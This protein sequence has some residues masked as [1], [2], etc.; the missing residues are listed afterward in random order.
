MTIMTTQPPTL[1]ASTTGRGAR[2]I[3]G[4]LAFS[5]GWT[6][7]FWALAGVTA[8]TVWAMPAVILFVIGGAGVLLGGVVMSRATYGRDGLRDLG[9]RIVDPRPIAGRWW[10]V[11]LLLF[12]ALV[13][14]SAGVGYLLGWSAAPVDLEGAAARLV[15]PA[16]LLGMVL[17]ILIIGPL[18][19]E[20]GWRGYLLDRLQLRW[21]ALVATLIIA[22]IWWSWHLPL[23]ALPGYFDAFGRDTP[24]PL[25]FLA[26]LV[27]AAILYTWVYNNTGRSVLAVILFHF[28]QNFSS[29]FL[30]IAA[31]TRPILLVLT[32]IV[33]VMVVLGWGPAALRR[34]ESEGPRRHASGSLA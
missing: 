30:G 16:R 11:I 9:R 23:F 7:L 4:F 8:E 31:E 26:A 28:L 12:P 10:A 13:L 5:H 19:E 24:H 27:P 2:D 18:P 20:V 6:W 14:V 22:V 25:D 29:E 15:R 1:A 3:L 17:F 21:N 32:W 33:A 34:A